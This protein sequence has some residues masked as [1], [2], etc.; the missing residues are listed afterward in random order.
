MAEEEV[1]QECMVLWKVL[2]VLGQQCNL[3]PLPALEELDIHVTSIEKQQNGKLFLKECIYQ[4]VHG[5]HGGM[6]VKIQLQLKWPPD[7]S[8]S[9]PIHSWLATQLVSIW[10]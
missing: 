9:S 3:F 4:L 8:I 5:H 2:S 1:F 7:S 6:K 10:H